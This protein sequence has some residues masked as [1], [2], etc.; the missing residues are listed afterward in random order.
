M[1]TIKVTVHEPD[2]SGI[3][4]LCESEMSEQTQSEIMIAWQ[5]Q[6]WIKNFTHNLGEAMMETHPDTKIIKGEGDGV[7]ALLEMFKR[8]RE[9]GG[10]ME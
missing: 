10:D 1:I 9:G 4:I 3:Q 7:D 8:E 5:I 2:D 6:Y